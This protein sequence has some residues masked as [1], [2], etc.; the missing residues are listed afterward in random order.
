MSRQ[1]EIKIKILNDKTIDSL[2]IALVRNGHSVYMSYD[3][4]DEREKE[5]CFL[6]TD[7]E[8]TLTSESDV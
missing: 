4:F 5:V 7:E 1:Y 3:S 2:I 6:A 8:V